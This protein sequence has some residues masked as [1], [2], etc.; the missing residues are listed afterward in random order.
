MKIDERCCRCSTISINTTKRSMVINEQELSIYLI[1]HAV[2]V[3]KFSIFRLFVNFLFLL[4]FMSNT[5]LNS[6][7]AL[8]VFS[9][10]SP[11]TTNRHE[12]FLTMI[13]E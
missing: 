11:P 9:F 7:E 10:Y 3:L 12:N 13:P 4:F 5:R 6:M 1:F 2:I 8:S